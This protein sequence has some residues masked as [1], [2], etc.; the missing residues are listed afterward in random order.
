MSR[1]FAGTLQQLQD[2]LLLAGLDGE[3][4]QQPNKVW[5]FVCRDGAGLNWSETKG[6][7]WFDGPPSPYLRCADVRKT[8]ASGWS[9]WLPNWV[10]RLTG[11]SPSLFAAVRPVFGKKGLYPGLQNR[12]GR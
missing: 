10:L 3:W 8:P 1:K 11:L 5:R 12:L 2:Q 4:R 7:M 9:R 6:T